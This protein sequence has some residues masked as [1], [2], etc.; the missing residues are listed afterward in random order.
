MKVFRA[1]KRAG[2]HPQRYQFTI[3]VTALEFSKAI[4]ELIPAGADL[5]DAKVSFLWKRGPRSV[6]SKTMQIIGGEQKAFS[7][8][9]QHYSLMCTLYQE[10]DKFQDKE[11]S[12]RIRVH[13]GSDEKVI[14][15]ATMNLAKYV[16][17]NEQP[18]LD[19][20]PLEKCKDKSA[21][22]KFSIVPKWI[23]QVNP[24]CV[25]SVFLEVTNRFVF[26]ER[27]PQVLLNR[28]RTTLLKKD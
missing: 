8:E 15:G 21:V 20:I 28:R 5:T 22:L 16:N 27:I 24:E 19:Q 10:K 14:G 4:S 23:S 11:A 9:G 18:V 12:I 3:T 26:A 25:Y 17:S 6:A 13:L 2:T 1:L 7:W